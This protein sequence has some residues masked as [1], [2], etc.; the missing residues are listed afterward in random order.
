M[1][2]ASRPSTSGSPTSMITRSIC[3]ALAA[4]TPLVPL[5]TAIDSNSSCSASLAQFGVVVHDQD[6]AGIRHSSAL[7]TGISPERRCA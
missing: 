5:S 4:C 3:P 1:R 7:R 6:L 2:T